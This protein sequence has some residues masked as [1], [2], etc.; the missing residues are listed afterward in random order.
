MNKKLQTNTINDIIRKNIAKHTD[1]FSVK[2][3]NFG[4]LSAK[5]VEIN[6][7]SYAPLLIPINVTILEF[8]N[9]STYYSPF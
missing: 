9:V 5:Y 6:C 4:S 1:V 2:L 7:S 8:T 3:L